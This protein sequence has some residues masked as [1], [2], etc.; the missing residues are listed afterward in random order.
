MLLKK[1][2]LKD[3]SDG[4]RVNHDIEIMGCLA[5]SFSLIKKFS[6]F[7]DYRVRICCLSGGLFVLLDAALLPNGYL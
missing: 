2:K 5:K 3:N 4:R 1:T 7:E 6:R